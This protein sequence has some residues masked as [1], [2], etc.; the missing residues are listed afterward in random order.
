[1]SNKALATGPSP[2]A[3]PQPE[4]FSTMT[5]Y[6][7]MLAPADIKPARRRLTLELGRAVLLY[8]DA[9]AP[10]IGGMWFIRQAALALLGIRVAMEFSPAGSK[11]EVTNAIE[12]LACWFGYRKRNWT[13]GD[14]RLRGPRKLQ[15]LEYSNRTWSFETLKDRA[16]YVTQPMRM[17]CVEALMGLGLVDAS[18]TRFNGFSINARGQQLID[19]VFDGR[20][21]LPDCLVSWVRGQEVE[22][23]SSLRVQLDPTT[24]IR[25]AARKVMREALSFPIDADRRLNAMAW[26]RR[27]DAGEGFGA[28]P[29]IAWEVRPTEIAEDH[30]KDMRAGATLMQ[31]RDAAINVVAEIEQYLVAHKRIDLS[32]PVPERLSD[33]LKQWREQAHRFR[34]L[35][36]HGPDGAA[37]DALKFCNEALQ[38]DEHAITMLVKRENHML[39]VAGRVVEPTSAWRKEAALSIQDASVSEVDPA[40]VE[41]SAPLRA[42]RDVLPPD[43]SV[44]MIY[45][46]RLTLDLEGRLGAFIAAQGQR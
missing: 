37:T 32:Q 23:T 27:I 6:W 1:M 12:A 45:L 26:L 44:R 36:G 46:R 3:D 18:G 24:E 43:I 17:G 30:W 25:E 8:N 11:I 7:G 33:A 13:R 5:V 35:D 2:Y 22:F 15:R 4:D 34:A 19:A 20:K 9:A 29:H 31:T 10:G 42:E 28:Q 21:S 38:P 14:W 40:D 16:S 41:G 39:R